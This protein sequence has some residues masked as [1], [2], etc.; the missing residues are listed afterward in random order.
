MPAGFGAEVAGTKR[1]GAL[2]NSNESILTDAGSW[3]VA[4]RGESLRRKSRDAASSS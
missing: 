1:F 3:M 4:S 2:L